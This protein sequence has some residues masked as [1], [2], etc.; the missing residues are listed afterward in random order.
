MKKEAFLQALED[1]LTPLGVEERRQI[2]AYYSELILDGI[3]LGKNEEE[4][5]LSLGSPDEAAARI[6]KDYE[7]YGQR[8]SSLPPQVQGGDYSAP[9]HGIRSIDIDTRDTPI[10]IAPAAGDTVRIAFHPRKGIDEVSSDIA[11]GTF[12]FRHRMRPFSF[13]IFNWFRTGVK[14]RLE[15]PGAYKG[16]VCIR[17]SNA[18]VHA[19]D[20]AAGNLNLITSNAKVSAE[21]INCQL[22]H[23]KTSNAKVI[24]GSIH[25][26]PLDIETTNGAILLGDIHAERVRAATSNARINAEHLTAAGEISLKTNN[27]ALTFSDLPCTRLELKTSNAPVTGMLYGDMRAYSIQSHTSNAACNLPANAVYPELEKSL[28]VHT[29]NGRIHIDFVR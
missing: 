16:D 1:R 27:A 2:C 3:E 24:V 14:I 22:L 9:A 6:I 21:R 19:A 11:D 28:S 26:L 7:D 13:H 17:T 18:S 23:I 5:I 12:T 10:E 25:C 4:I 15:I 20:L 8:L 29:S